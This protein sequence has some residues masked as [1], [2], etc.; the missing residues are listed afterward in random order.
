MLGAS[1]RANHRID[2]GTTPVELLAKL[3]AGDVYLHQVT[4]VEGRASRSF[5]AAVRAHPAI[6]AGSTT[7][8]GIMAS[9]EHPTCIPKGSSPGHVS[10][11]ERDAGHRHLPRSACALEARLD[12]AWNSRSADISR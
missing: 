3:V 9:S 1:V 8:A 11:P 10:L 2:P 7:G 4:V 5:L 12:A 6:V